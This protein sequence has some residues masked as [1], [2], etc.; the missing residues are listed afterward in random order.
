MQLDSTSGRAVVVNG[1]EYRYFAGTAYLGIPT[2]PVFQSYLMEG[3]QRYGGHYGGSR[4]SNL[5]YPVFEAVEAMLSQLSHAEAA[6]VVSSGTLAGQLATKTLAQQGRKL[7]YAPDAHP[8]LFQQ[9][10]ELPKLAYSHW[11]ERILQRAAATDYPLAFCCNAIDPLRLQQYSFDWIRALPKNKQFTLVL[12][13]SHGIGITGQ[14]GGGIHTLLDLPSH[15]DLIVIASLGKAFGIPAGV[16]LGSQQFITR[17][18][19]S[20]F[21]GGA[22]PASPAYLYTFLKCQA[23]FEQQRKYLFQLVERFQEDNLFFRSL[24]NY[25]V[26]T[27]G[28]ADFYKK[29]LAK[30]ILI[31]S[32]AYPLPSSPTLTRVIL[33]AAHQVEDVEYL[34]HEINRLKFIKQ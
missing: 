4:L 11:I 29:L 10:S 9:I 3:I 15:V 26:F 1:K 31:S 30:K 20:S 27:T 23:L 28:D 34:K 33:N 22:S 19:E 17:L 14:N 12:D 13:D 8:A 24:P 16:I 25:P 18:K 7:V 32:F 6:L 5:Q 2:H 21:F